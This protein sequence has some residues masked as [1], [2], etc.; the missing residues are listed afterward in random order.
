MSGDAS[1]PLLPL[2]HHNHV[3]LRCPPALGYNKCFPRVSL[4]RDDYRGGGGGGGGYP[5]AVPHGRGPPPVAPP[6]FRS[7]GSAHRVLVKGLPM[8]ASWQDLK[9]RSPRYRLPLD[10]VVGQALWTVATAVVACH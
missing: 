3:I 7:K 5:A 10:E 6:N 1:T 2:R 4:C 9:V 8:S